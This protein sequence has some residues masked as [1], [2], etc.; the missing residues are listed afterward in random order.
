VI[1]TVTYDATFNTPMMLPD[2][3]T[4]IAD[5]GNL[6]NECNELNNELS[7]PV[8]S[9]DMQ[10]DLRIEVTSVTNDCPPDVDAT[11]FNDGSLEAANVVVRFYSGDPNQGGTPLQEFTI[12]GPIPAG[13]SATLSETLT[14]FNGSAL[15]ATIFAI[16]DPDNAIEECNDGNN[17]DAG[18]QTVSC[19]P[20]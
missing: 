5:V 10:A 16:V 1:V 11:V 19:A 4:V 8:D 6:A 3:I 2:E 12:A 15:N 18:D 20:Q 9:G 7:E 17:K 14:S 13:G